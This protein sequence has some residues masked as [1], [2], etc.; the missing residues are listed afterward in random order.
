VLLSVVNSRLGI[1]Y[2]DFEHSA[3]RDLAWLDA[4]LLYELSSDA[5][6]L[7]F[8]ELSNGEGRNAAIYLRKTDGSPAVRLGFGNRPSLS[9][10]G[11]WIVCIRH[12]PQRSRLMLLP[13][14][15]GESRFLQVDGVHFESLGWFP[16]SRRVVFTGTAAGHPVRTWTYDLDSDKPTPLTAEGTRGSQVSPDGQWFV[17]A[18]PH[19]LLLASIG[20]GAPR[21]IIPLQNGEAVVR[22]SSDG[23]QLFLQQPEGDAIK[24]SRLDVAT[25]H[26]ELWQ[27]LKVPEPGAEF[28]GALALAADGKSCAF[29]FQHDLANLYLVRGLK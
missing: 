13:T 6:S 23:R 11:K 18:D 5:K 21:T 14:G 20:G 2:V 9:P 24:I 26:K 27:T 3:E 22:W 17:M 12:E 29:S 15:P 1:R 19:K 4:S 25:G 8:V 16:D 7:L 28:I 10:D